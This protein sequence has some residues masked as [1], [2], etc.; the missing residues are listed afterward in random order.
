[1]SS[2]RCVFVYICVRTH[3]Q[4]CTCATFSIWDSPIEPQE[5]SP[6]TPGTWP[7]WGPRVQ[8]LSTWAHGCHRGWPRAEW[9]KECISESPAL[10][11]LSNHLHPRRRA[12][13][14]RPWAGV[15]WHVGED[16]CCPTG[17]GFCFKA[18]KHLFTFGL[19]PPEA[20]FSFSGC[21]LSAIKLRSDG[22]TRPILYPED[23][24]PRGLEGQE[25]AA[26]W[27]KKRLFLSVYYRTYLTPYFGNWLLF[28]GKQNL[29]VRELQYFHWKN[30]LINLCEI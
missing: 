19:S 30:G 28:Q 24:A 14:K 29:K 6:R 3:V 20:S 2:P 5:P 13:L 7:P 25:F 1:M 10:N 15:P 22:I 8:T 12:L 27:T 21:E 18:M 4:T 9:S 23:P 17:P 16:S 26:L 11:T